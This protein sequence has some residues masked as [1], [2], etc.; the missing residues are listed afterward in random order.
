[1]ER[2]RSATTGSKDQING[3]KTRNGTNLEN[4]HLKSLDCVKKK[5]RR[6]HRRPSIDLETSRIFYSPFFIDEKYQ[7][8]EKPSSFSHFPFNAHFFKKKKRDNK[9]DRRRETEQ[10]FSQR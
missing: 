8:I 1:M 6:D 10:R 2:N 7:T 9:E 5:S 4:L 3:Q